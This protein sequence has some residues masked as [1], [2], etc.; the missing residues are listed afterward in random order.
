MCSFSIFIMS[1]LHFLGVRAAH[2]HVYIERK[3]KDVKKRVKNRETNEY[4]MNLNY[5]GNGSL[6]RSRKVKH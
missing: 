5:L 1:F 3:K 6:K 2:K 4:T